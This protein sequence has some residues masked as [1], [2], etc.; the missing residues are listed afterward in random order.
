MIVEAPI[1]FLPSLSALI[2]ELFAKKFPDKRVRIE[3]FSI[4]RIFARKESCSP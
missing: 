1:A 3:M 4:M 2:P